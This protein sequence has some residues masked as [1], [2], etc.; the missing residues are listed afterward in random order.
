MALTRW[1]PFRFR[2]RAKEEKGEAGERQAVPVRVNPPPP[3]RW[4]EPWA[5]PAADLF[6]PF[7]WSSWDPFAGGWPVG[8]WFGDFSPAVFYP[9]IDVV[10]EGDAIRVSAEL[11]GLDRDDVDVTIREGA[12]VLRGEKRIE[13]E[14]REAGC[15]RIERA[16]GSFERTIPLPADVDID[17]AEGRFDR[18]V[19]S[20]R[21]PKTATGRAEERKIPIT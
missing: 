4:G 16:W 11:P 12:L 8:T 15:Y 9:R 19:L 10:D 2:R 1:L 3:R 20:V 18:G 7:A 17:R 6:P 13:N 14:S 5:G 21:V